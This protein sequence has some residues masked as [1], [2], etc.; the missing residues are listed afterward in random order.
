M[1]FKKFLK[2]FS[3]VFFVGIIFL[4]Y[5][6]YTVQTIVIK[7]LLPIIVLDRLAAWFDRNIPDSHPKKHF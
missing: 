3:I 5:D 2:L 1:S 7:F 6:D 4:A